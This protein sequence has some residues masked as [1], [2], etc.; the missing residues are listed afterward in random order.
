M[1][2]STIVDLVN[3]LIKK[4]QNN[5]LDWSYDHEN[6][7]IFLELPQSNLTVNLRYRFDEVYECGIFFI[8]FNLNKVDYY[9]DAKEGYDDEYFILKNLYDLAQSSHFQKSFSAIKI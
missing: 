2:P 7:S 3:Q 1:I 4:T 8:N 6:S 9:F 5:E